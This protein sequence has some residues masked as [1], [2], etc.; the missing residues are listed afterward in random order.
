MCPNQE[1]RR[2]NVRGTPPRHPL[3]ATAQIVPSSRLGY[4]AQGDKVARVLRN[5]MS[6]A[7]RRAGKHRTLGFD[8]RHHARRREGGTLPAG[9]VNR[10]GQWAFRPIRKAWRVGSSVQPDKACVPR[11][12][13][14]WTCV[15][16]SSGR[17]HN[18]RWA[19]RPNTA[20]SSGCDCRIDGWRSGSLSRR[21]RQQAAG[22]QAGLTAAERDAKAA[23]EQEAKADAEQEQEA[24]AAAEQEANTDGELAGLIAAER[25]AKAAAKQDAKAAAGEEAEAIGKQAGLTAAKRDANAGAE[26]EAKEAGAQAGSTAAEREAEAAADQEAKAAAEQEAKPAA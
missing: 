23:A 20:R 10:V 24:N 7:K 14:A 2:P 25:E 16:P 19:H 21:S 5:P 13:R 9:N 11:K 26:Q 12:E 17:G 3:V 8:I 1:H 4:T 22:E 6:M 15:C 18:R